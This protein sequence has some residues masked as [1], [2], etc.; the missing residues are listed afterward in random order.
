[1]N[2]AAGR[3][4]RELNLSVPGTGHGGFVRNH[5][6]RCAS[7]SVT[8][9]FGAP[10]TRQMFNEAGAVLVSKS[11]RSAVRQFLLRIL[12]AVKMR[13]FRLH[14]RF[15][16]DDPADTGMLLP[17]IAPLIV[18][19]SSFDGSLDSFVTIC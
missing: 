7:A 15:G 14:V 5:M 4:A 9:P 2:N 18:T 17:A 10:G 11:G 6:W 13:D 16:F 8:R 19:L 1:V 3:L 12:L